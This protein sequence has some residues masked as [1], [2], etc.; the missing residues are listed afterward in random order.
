MVPLLSGEYDPKKE[1][2]SVINVISVSCAPDP[3]D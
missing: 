3:L 2:R 1:K